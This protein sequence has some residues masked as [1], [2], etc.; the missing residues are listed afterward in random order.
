M[1]GRKCHISSVS[2]FYQGLEYIQNIFSHS[3]WEPVT[4][5]YWDKLKGESQKLRLCYTA[6]CSRIWI[7]SKESEKDILRNSKDNIFNIFKNVISLIAVFLFRFC[8]SMLCS[9]VAN[10]GTHPLSVYFS[11]F[12]WENLQLYQKSHL[13]LGNLAILVFW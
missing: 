7:K 3:L 4:R 1:Q 11:I 9:I 13:A 2:F 8:L 10:F 5:D 6:C 12:E